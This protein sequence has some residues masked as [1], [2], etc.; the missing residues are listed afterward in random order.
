L[1]PLL[2]DR[3]YSD[4]TKMVNLLT[5]VRREY[6]SPEQV[7]EILLSVSV[8]N[9]ELLTAIESEQLRLWPDTYYARGMPV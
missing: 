4:A 6:K 7:A 1:D 3:I 2:R 9:R 8:L 5:Q